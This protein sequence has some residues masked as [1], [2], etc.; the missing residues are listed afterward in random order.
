LANNKYAISGWKVDPNNKNSV[1]FV[2]LDQAGNI[3]GNNQYFYGESNLPNFTTNYPLRE[4]TGQNASLLPIKN[5]GVIT[6]IMIGENLRWTCTTVTPGMREIDFFAGGLLIKIDLSGNLDLGFGNGGYKGHNY[7]NDPDR[8]GNI[9][10]LSAC[11]DNT[12]SNTTGY[13]FIGSCHN[14]KCP[15]TCTNQFCFTIPATRDRDIWSRRIDLNGSMIFEKKYEEADLVSKGYLDVTGTTNYTG[16]NAQAETN[17]QIGFEIY[18]T[19]LG[20]SQFVMIAGV[21]YNTAYGSNPCANT[22]VI[23]NCISSLQT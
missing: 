18:Q 3:I 9:H 1:F 5:A 12:G 21:D 22:I 14:T 11:V 17:E 19:N 2:V 16:S 20:S 6:G 4:T 23:C 8:R 13:I 15:F 10:H 7:L